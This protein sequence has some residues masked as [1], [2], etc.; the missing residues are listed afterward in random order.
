MGAEIALEALHDA[1]RQ[2]KTTI[3]ELSRVA[4]VLPSR[5]LSTALDA[6]AL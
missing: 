6:V 5:R 3:A 4:E 1:L 2:R